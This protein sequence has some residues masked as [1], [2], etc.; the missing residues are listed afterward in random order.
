MSRNVQDRLTPQIHVERANVHNLKDVS[1]DIPR[2]QLVVLTGPSGSGKS[3]LA[4]DT[5]YAEGRRQYIES[6]SLDAREM[7]HQIE[8]PDVELISGLQPTISIN[9]QNGSNNPRSTVATMTEI[10]DYLRV[11]YSRFGVAH[12]WNCGRAIRQQSPEQ[13]LEEVLTLPENCRVMLLA[14]LV[15]GGRGTHAE[16]FRKIIKAGLVRA[17][18]D[19][20]II[21]VEDPPELDPLARHDIEVIVDRIILREGIQ[22]RLLESLKLAVKFGEGLAIVSY[23]KERTTNPDGTTKSAWKD[24]LYST[25]YTCPKCKINYVELE[26]RTFSFNSPYGACPTCQGMGTVETFDPELLVP[27]PTLSLAQGAIAPWKGASGTSAKLYQKYYALFYDRVGNIADVPL[28]QWT[29][30][31]RNLFFW[32]EETS[33]DQHHESEFGQESIAFPGIIAILEEV[34]QA[35]QSRKTLEQWEPFRNRIRCRECGGARLRREARNVTICQYRIHEVCA[36]TVEQSITFFRSL[37]LPD[38][39]KQATASLV[40]QVLSRLDFLDQIGVSYLTLDRAA[41]SL[42][43]GELQRIRLATGLGTGLVGVCYVLDEPSV[44]LHP[45]DNHRLIHTMRQLQKKGNTVLVVEHDEAIMRAS[46]WL[47]DVGP[48]AGQKGGNI[49]AQGTPKEVERHSDSLTGLYLAGKHAIPIPE[50][51]RKTVA[52]RSIVLEGCTLHNLKDLTVRFPLGVL[53]C[54]TGVSG[55]GKSSLVNETLVAAIAK[56]LYH[57]KTLPGPHKSLRGINKIDKLICID[58]SPIGRSPRSNAA[59]YTGILDEIRKVFAATK[60]AKQRGYTSSR[61]SFNVAGGRCETCLGHGMRKI[62]MHFLPDLY[63]A[64]PICEGKRFNRQTLSIKYKEKSMADVLEMSVDDAIEFFE[65]HPVISRILDSLN[66]VGLGY[67]SLGQPSTTL[68]GGEAQRIKLATELAK[69]ETGKTLYVLDEPTSGLHPH[70]VSHLL[71]VLSGLV[72]LGNTVIVIEHNLDVA[73][74]ADWIID[75]GPEGGERGG[76]LLAEGTPE[77]IAA[78]PD[79]ETGRFLQKVLAAHKK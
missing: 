79:N 31:Q 5:I 26:P 32:G 78:L 17:R 20:V 46:D 58:Q 2:N 34:F 16:V 39:Q 51:R 19:G 36:L 13:I 30:S 68:S 76:Y 28:E 7:L 57:S 52:S 55:S 22:S 8:R 14:P 38:H 48:G 70:D 12:C 49:I 60:D 21:D 43:G 71:D 9:Q 29:E 23:E 56:K 72:D 18:V 74:T 62:E 40:E 6:L 77:E 42:S 64:C 25:K 35:K 45:G 75:L 37:E 11:L 69:V 15:R 67:L 59:T 44:G 33:S 27:E 63:A 41:D 65:N 54:V 61:F 66:R 50:K 73:K 10:Y 24:L 4:F 3:S 1:V 53:T 47:I